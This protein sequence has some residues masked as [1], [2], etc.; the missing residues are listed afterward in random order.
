MSYITRLDPLVYRQLVRWGL[1]DAV[2][3]EV[4]LHLNDRLPRSPTALLI[5]DP[6]LFEDEGMTY[7]FE[8]IDPENRLLEHHFLFQVFYHADEQTLIIRR[9]IHITRTGS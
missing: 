4:H 2:R 3:V 6:S 8:L 9:G 5:R 1:S 7:Q